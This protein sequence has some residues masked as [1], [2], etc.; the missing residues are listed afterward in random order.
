[1][2][3]RMDFICANA[4]RLKRAYHYTACGLDNVYLH[5]GVVIEKDPDYGQLI[6]IEREQDLQRAIALQLI[7]TGRSLNGNE[8]RFLRKLM[9]QTQVDLARIMKVDVQT[10]A[11]YEKKSNIP[12]PSQQLMRMLVLFHVLPNEV[13]A[14]AA[15]SVAHDEP[16]LDTLPQRE[17]RKVTQAWRERALA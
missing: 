3:E 12:G 5:S 2:T 16:L 8:F 4:P 17:L 7:E 9:K 6:T 13:S 11:N 14:K 10:I 1:M 15:K